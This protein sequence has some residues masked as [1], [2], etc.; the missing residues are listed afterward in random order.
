MSALLQLHLHFQL[1]TWLQSIGQRQL[2]NETRNIYVLGLGALILENWRYMFSCVS[3][4]AT[5]HYLNQWGIPLIRPMRKTNDMS[6]I[7]FVFR[8]KILICKYRQ[9]NGAHFVPASGCWTY[10]QFVS[11]PIIVLRSLSEIGGV[12][13]ARQGVYTAT[14]LRQYRQ[15]MGD[16]YYSSPSGPHG[17]EMNHPG[18]YWGKKH[19]VLIDIFCV[20]GIFFFDVVTFE[21]GMVGSPNP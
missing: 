15:F 8:T 12:A 16:K 3:W 7:Y 13:H 9:H 11:L 4:S 2:Q 5:N 14:E 20:I 10:K 17:L 18:L 6:F 19:T 1:N 21:L